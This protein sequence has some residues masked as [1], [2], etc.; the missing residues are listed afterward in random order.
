MIKARTCAAAAAM[1]TMAF[2]A[3][4]LA[5]LN[6]GA[7]DPQARFTAS[8]FMAN[9]NRPNDLAPLPD[10]RAVV[11]QR[12]GEIIIRT[13]D[14]M[15]INPAVRMPV[16]P[17]NNDN[18]QGLIG[19]LAHP[20]FA[21]NHTLFFLA[22]V[23]DT[24][25]EKNHVFKATLSDD[26]KFTFDYANPLVKME[27]PHKHNGSVMIIHKNQ[28]YIGVG[29][30]GFETPIPSNKYASCLNKP[31]GKILRIELDGSIPK[32]NPLVGMAMVTG[33]TTENMRSG[34]FSM[35][36]PETRIY[37]W[38]LRAPYRFWLDPMTDL[39]WIA[40]VGEKEQEELSIGGKG[41]HFGYPFEEGT[42]KYTAG[43]EPFNTFGGCT[44][45]VPSTPCAAPAFTYPN[46]GASGD[47]SIIGGLIPSGCGWAAP[48]TS[49]Y[50]FGDH[51]SGRIWTLDVTPDRRGVVAG[52][53]QVFG[54]LQGLNG[55]RMAADGTLYVI[56]NDLN[57]IARLQ[58]KDRPANC[59]A[60]SADGGAGP[61]SGGAGGTDGPPRDAAASGDA[62]A[63]GGS[64]GGGSGGAGAGGSGA[65]GSGAGGA[66]AGGAGAGGAGAGG[67]AGSGGRGDEGGAGT[68][69]GAGGTAAQSPGGCGCALG[70]A[71]EPGAPSL[72]LAIALL[73]LARATRRTGRTGR[74]R[75]AISAR[76]PST[77]PPRAG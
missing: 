29:D 22:S 59:A 75:A 25:A 23:G 21:Q 1:M 47:D 6:L 27:A 51:G 20:D 68:T 12:G 38:G 46:G 26:N 36:P 18:E 30:G 66:G 53:R 70:G 17:V 35:Q 67:R 62:P 54:T 40:D 13:A 49:R 14:G 15:L 7:G 10:G 61:G 52:S 60:A 32:D 77:T 65:G 28:L 63:S 9:L 33:C 69:G 41:L 39:L 64:S 31:N 5:Q 76:S 11:I 16:K 58:P 42:H 56:S 8:N 71:H 48:Y 45:M 44:G 2:G 50:F 24:I 57:A 19:I 37:S 3:S 74:E 73:A 55:F 43:Q 4:A 72:G 34:G